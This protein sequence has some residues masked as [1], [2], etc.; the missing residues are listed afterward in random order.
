MAKVS[1]I[2][3]PLLLVSIMRAGNGMLEGSLD[4][5]PFAQV[6][7]IG[8]YRDKIIN[9]TVE[10]YLRTPP[11]EDHQLAL[12]LDPLL[13]TGSTAIAAVS[14]L[15][16]LGLKHIRFLCVLASATGVANM[17]AQH[18]DVDVYTLSVEHSLDQNGFILPGI[19]DA[20]GRLYG[21]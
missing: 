12:V 11:M 19:G 16:E 5:L 15:K 9:S 20:G 18:A 1:V 6:A 17:Q 8:I 14:R 21:T 2:T 4:A 13:A 3:R 7:H 10:Y